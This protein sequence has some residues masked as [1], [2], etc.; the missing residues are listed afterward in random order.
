MS[1]RA[2]VHAFGLARS[3]SD[4]SE[5]AYAVDVAAGRIALADGASSAW[6]AGDWAAMLAAAWVAAPSGRLRGSTT[7]GFARWAAATQDRFTAGDRGDGRREWFTEE[8]ARRGSHAA[9]LALTLTELDGR[10]PSWHAFAVGDVCAFHVRSEQLRQAVPLDD[11]AR[12]TSH[13]DLLSSLPR[14]PVPEPVVGEGEL[15]EHDMLVLAR[16][17]LAAFLLRLDRAAEP[18]WPAVRGLDAGRFREFV[19]QGIAA[20]LLERD[21]TTLVRIVLERGAG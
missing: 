10:S 3:R 5:D 21:D 18:V 9:L 17:A 19:A 20:G 8:A 14:A 4:P 16:D 13:P 15:R 12:F 7:P 2:V 11:P 1:L 6:R